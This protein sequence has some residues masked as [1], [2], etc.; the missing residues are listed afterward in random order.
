MVL[1]S[2]YYV[3][4][5]FGY[6]FSSIF[7]VTKHSAHRQNRSNKLKRRQPK[8]TKRIS[9]DERSKRYSAKILKRV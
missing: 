9:K 3:F 5:C 8:V 4:L 6:I 7:T 2:I 1:K